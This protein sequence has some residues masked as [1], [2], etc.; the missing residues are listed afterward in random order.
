[1]FLRL[2]YAFGWLIWVFIEHFGDAE[3]CLVTKKAQTRKFVPFVLLKQI[4]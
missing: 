2:F 3:V 1:M 4:V